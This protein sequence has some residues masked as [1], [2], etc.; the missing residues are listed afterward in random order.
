MTL[1]SY[2]LVGSGIPA[3]DV[4]MPTNPQDVPDVPGDAPMNPAPRAR[5]STCA[6]LTRRSRFPKPLTV[7]RPWI[8]PDVNSRLKMMICQGE[9]RTSR[10]RPIS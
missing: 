8:R 1:M 2:N 5:S 6:T 3:P 10:Q 4:P 9:K 7:T